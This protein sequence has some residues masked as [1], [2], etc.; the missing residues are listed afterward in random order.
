[1]AT[2]LLVFGVR[3][4]QSIVFLKLDAIFFQISSML[5]LQY[6]TSF[7]IYLWSVC[8]ANYVSGS[9]S[10]RSYQV[11]DSISTQAR[12]RDEINRVPAID[13]RDAGGIKFD[14]DDWEATIE[15][16]NLSFAYPS[17]PDTK[18]LDCVSLKIPSGRVTAIV[19]G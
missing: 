16:Q 7:L 6:P 8:C 17:R 15:L 1:M 3:F 10:G 4:F 13:V 9:L 14:G 2:F 18:S 5:F 12:L 11:I 19:G